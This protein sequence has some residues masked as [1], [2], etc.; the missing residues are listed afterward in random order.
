MS[1]SAIHGLNKTWNIPP[2][3]N[4]TIVSYVYF[5]PD[6]LSSIVYT[7]P[8]IQLGVEYLREAYNFNVTLQYVGHES[9]RNLPDLAADVYRVASFYYHEW[10]R[11]G[12]IAFVLPGMRSRCSEI[13][14]KTQNTTIFLH[15]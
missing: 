12:I 2:V 3:L 14:E 6:L 15:M 7:G 10:D 8:G 11:N 13:I 9:I 1:T 5:Y 4:I